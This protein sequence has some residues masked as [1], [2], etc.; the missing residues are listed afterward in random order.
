M[1]FLDGLPNKNQLCLYHNR[2]SSNFQNYFRRFNQDRLFRTVDSRDPQAKRHG[3]GKVYC[4]NDPVCGSHVDSRRKRLLDFS[5][6]LAASDVQARCSM[7]S[8]HGPRKCA[9]DLRVL[10][11]E[12]AF[13]QVQKSLYAFAARPV[14]L[15]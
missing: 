3:Q 15:L 5:I 11:A 7:R 8:W 12:Y 13:R 9:T 4:R 14:M 6:D 1:H 2:S 10:A